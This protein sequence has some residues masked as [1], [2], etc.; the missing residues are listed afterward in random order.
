[1]MRRS[2]ATLAILSGQAGKIYSYALISCSERKEN[3]LMIQA[4]KA[5][6]YTIDISGAIESDPRVQRFLKSVEFAK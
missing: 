6:H 1:M 3:V 5:H 2:V 4:S